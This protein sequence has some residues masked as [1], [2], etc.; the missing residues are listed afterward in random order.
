MFAPIYC[1][2]AF[3]GTWFLLPN[4]IQLSLYSASSSTPLGGANNDMRP[5]LS[6]NS[7]IHTNLLVLQG[8]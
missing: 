3:A 5:M 8:Y 4:V 2:Y 6:L 7:Q 1:T